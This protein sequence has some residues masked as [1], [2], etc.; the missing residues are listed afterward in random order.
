MTGWAILGTGAVASKFALDLGQAGGRVA[1][2]GSRDPDRARAFLANLPARLKTPDARIGSAAEAVQAP[3][4]QAVYIATPPSLHEVQAQ[5]AFAAG[6]AVLIEKPIAP[7]AET[8]R[9]IAEAAASAGVFC[10]EALWTRFLPMTQQISGLLDRQ[11]L[12]EVRAF[13]ADFMGSDRPDPGLS[14]FDPALGGGALLHRGIYPLSLAL[15]FL[16]PVQALAATGRLGATGVE[17]EAVIV[18]THRS[19]AISTLR[20]SLRGGGANGMTLSG[21]EA[22]LVVEGPVF[23][24]FRAQLLRHGQRQ[25]G[26]TGGI[27]GGTG[28]GHRMRGWRESGPA[29][30]LNR[31]L[32]AGPLAELLAGRPG[33][34]LLR[35]PPL[36]NGYGHQAAEVARAL[37]AAE[38]QSP[39][40]PLADSIEALRLIDQA[41]DLIRNAAQQEPVAPGSGETA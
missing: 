4:V 13:Q 37:A 10:M 32:T 38:R 22:S 20:S 1:A 21:T 39:L 5:L 26:M 24:P 23:R 9:R 17:E 19:G 18:L 12:G 3:G 34:G 41:R 27:A 28:G 30:A 33:G 6:R 40:L 2:V 35:A 8:A 29:Q 15:L 16:G 36:G 14:L 25:G 7:D 11:A 31:L